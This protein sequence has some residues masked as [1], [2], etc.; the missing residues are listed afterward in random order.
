V[1][2]TAVVLP[3][4]RYGHAQAGLRLTELALEQAGVEL[5]RVDWPAEG[6]PTDPTEAAEA[7]AA[8]A[9]PLLDADPA[10]VVAKSLGTLAAPLAA[11]RGLACIWLTPLLDEPICRDAILRNPAPQLLA[12]GEVDFAWDRGVAD[13]A[14]NAGAAAVVLPRADHGF[15][16]PGDAV[17]SAEALVMLTRAVTQ[18]L[19]GSPA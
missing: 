17:A 1:T 10:Y 12:G 19:A 7:V 8:I 15:E 9:T 3:G 6:M 5:V 2:R 11:D 14:V 16:V 18:W 13:H 4:R